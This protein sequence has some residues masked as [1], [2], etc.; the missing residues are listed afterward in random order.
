MNL[1]NPGLLL[2]LL[3]GWLT[4]GPAIG[5]VPDSELER[6][7]A[8]L[9]TDPDSRPEHS[10]SR[11]SRQSLN[12]VVVVGNDVT[13]KE[14]E[15]AHDVVVVAGSA[16]VDGTIT[17]EFVVIFGNVKVG[18]TANIRRGLQVIAGD[19][20]ADPAAHIGR[21]RV[22]IGRSHGS[23]KK[24]SWIGWPAQWFNTGLL[25]A[26]PLP[27]QYG[28]S[29]AIA[30]IALLLYLTLAVL[31]PR[32]VQASVVALEERP[33]NSLLTGMLAFVLAG[34]LLLLLAVTVVGLIVIPFALCA[35]V[36]AFLF[37]KVAVYR[38]AGQQIGSQ[39]GSGALQKPLLALLIGA[40]LF[41]II[42]T[43]PVIGFLVWGVVAPLGL[44]AVLLAVFKRSP[45]PAAVES[46]MSSATGL[47]GLAAGAVPPVF[48]SAQTP[49][50][51][52]RVGFWWRFLATA[53]DL[54]LVA[55]V[56]T[57]VF[58]RPGWFLLIW[59]VY[60]LVLWSWKGTTL[61][62]IVFGLKIVRA[63]GGPMNF[64]VALVRLLGS[65]FSAAVLGL[66][67]F[68][69]GWSHDKQSWH[70]KIAGT[71]VVKFPKVTP[72]L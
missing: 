6:S 28:W 30:G 46:G 72:L 68:W 21:D 2:A 36:V 32:Q 58:H 23:L 44:G 69:A 52:P 4:Y 34:P 57:A 22:V 11:N 63:D 42:Y 53:L 31:F 25:M 17:G 14:G 50:L 18:P 51:L 26:R 66:G 35:M 60:H 45:R 40:A 39:L 70:D 71:F 10:R 56:M 61:G 62:G 27:H 65:F 5:Q 13:I 43:V 47:P 29:W 24:L 20:D 19:L 64:A 48:P 37:G 41:C 38:Y 7:S 12:D 15:T 16:Q 8:N 1:F 54:A 49:E 59:V 67:F 9:K 55:I 33:G 3:L